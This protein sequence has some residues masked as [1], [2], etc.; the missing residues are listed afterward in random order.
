MNRLSYWDWFFKGSGGKPGVRRLLDRWTVFHLGVGLGLSFAV[1]MDLATCAGT[2]LL[3]L[4]GIL[5][6][7]SFAW[8]GN[9][10]ALLQS[11]EMEDLS[12]HHPGGYP[13]YVYVFQTAILAILST[14]VIWG[15]AGLR[16]FDDGWPTRSS[17]IQYFLIKTLL[18]LLSSL[19][20][21]ECWHVVVGAQLMLLARW[22]IRSER[23]KGETQQPTKEE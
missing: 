2:V 9:A 12:K 6:G 18:F 4:A 10:Q 23:S 8:A 3:P 11:A 5:V 14:L 7:L 15:L 20:L 21:R 17:R 1:K 13:E 22:R 16:L 19:T